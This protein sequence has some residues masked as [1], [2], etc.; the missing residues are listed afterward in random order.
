M[1]I[2][3]R[4]VV[5]P[6]K[7]CHSPR[8]GFTRR[9]RAPH[10]VGFL[11]THAPTDVSAPGK[12]FLF[13]EYAV[14][15]GGQ[16]IVTATSRRVRA[17]RHDGAGY[18][19]NGQV[20]PTLPPLP[21][22]VAQTLSLSTDQASG[23]ATDARAFFEKDSKLG[24]GSSAASTVA[25]TALA[26]DGPCEPNKVFGEALRAHV[27]LQ[28]GRGSG[29]DVAASAFGG[30][31]AYQRRAPQAPFGALDALP[32][33]EGFAEIHA[34]QW[35]EGLRVEALWL[36]TPA[37]SVSFIKQVEQA[38]AQRKQLIESTFDL[39]HMTTRDVLKCFGPDPTE[40]LDVLLSNV[41]IQNEAMN[42][43]GLGSGAPILIEA[44]RAL[45]RHTQPYGLVTKPSGAGGGD[46]SLVFG[47][48][49]AKWDAMLAAL[50]QS[51]QHL[52]VGLHA[53]GVRVDA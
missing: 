44:H 45:M 12:L 22:H 35:P 33:G 10:T 8:I 1:F 11:M 36:G 43:L 3:N 51:I 30:T 7:E 16:S 14:L 23:W 34:L 25:L 40:G 26:Q 41:S 27:A 18:L 15:A 50:P 29:A 39:I 47:P 6:I 38:Y 17:T 42:A 20:S 46:F 5:R 52:N 48:Q 13:G 19:F 28:G 21:M 24:L 37:H 4:L 9:V 31:I 53:E 32:K 2:R 49:D